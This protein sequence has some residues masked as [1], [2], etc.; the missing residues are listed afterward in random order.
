MPAAADG[1]RLKISENI[2]YPN[3]NHHTHNPNFQK[4]TSNKKKQT[5]SAVYNILLT[6]E[7]NAPC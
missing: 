5:K 4:K 6:K 7:L 2:Y 1:L 3:K